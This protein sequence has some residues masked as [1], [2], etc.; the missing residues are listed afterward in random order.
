MTKWFV[1]V[2]TNCADP[3]REAEYN[4]WYDNIHLPD[5]LE[6]PGYVRATRYVNTEPSEGQAKFLAIYE[7]EADDIDKVRKASSANLAKKKE[8]G[9]M[10]DLVRMVSR[11]TY[12]QIGS[13]SK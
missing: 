5:V 12:K 6:T 9:R 10:S 8:Q 7:I 1:L 2:G 4:D 3:T 11:A 13:R